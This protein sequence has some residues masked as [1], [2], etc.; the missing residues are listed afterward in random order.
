MGLFSGE[1]VGTYEIVSRIGQGGMG[2]VYRARDSKL[3]REV[4]LKVLPSS[5]A[6]DPHRRSMLLHE[7]Q[8]LASLNHPSI[9]S[10]YDLVEAEHTLALVLEL[11]EGPTLAD[12]IAQGPLPLD[13]A[14]G[15]ALRIVDALDVAH[16]KGIVHRDLKPA[17]I[18]VDAAG[19][20]KVLDFGIAK[21]LATDGPGDPA[22]SPTFTALANRSGVILGT[23]AYMSPE[24]A[25]GK[26]VDK[27]ADIWAFGCVLFEMLTGRQMFSGDDLTEIL[28]AVMTSEPDWQLLPANTP[29]GVREIL[30]RCVKRSTRERLRDIADARAD[31][32]PSN[33]AEVPAAQP[34]SRPRLGVVLFQR[35]TD[36]V[37]INGSPAISPDGKM[38]AFVAE[39]HGRRHVWVRLLAG[40]TPLKLTRADV[41]HEAPRWA[42]DS[43]S[44]I[45]Y[46]KGATAGD[47]GT[48]WEISALGGIPRPIASALG[49]GDISHDG[50]RIAVFQAVD[51]RVEL[52]LISR[53]GATVDHVRPLPPIVNCDCP[54]WSPDD[55]EIAFQAH[56]AAYF[57]QRLFIVPASGSSHRDIVRGAILRGMTWLADG[58]TIV[59][60]SAAGSTLPYPPIFGL[61][62]INRDGSDDR[63]VT[64]DDTS[65]VEPD[66]HHSG[67]LV[68]S[69]LRSRSDIWKFP[70]TGTPVENVGAAVRVTHQAGRVQTPSVSPDGSE[71]VYLSDS[72]GHATLWVTEVATGETRQVT[73]EQDSRNAVGVPVW[74]PKGDLI[75]FLMSREGQSRLWVVRPDGNGLRQ[76]ESGGFY[77]C[78]SGDGDWLYYSPPLERPSRIMKSPL[79]GGPAV[80]VRVDNAFSPAVARDGQT[81]YYAAMINPGVGYSD[82]EIRAA[83]PE[84]GPCRVLATVSGAQIPVSPTLLHMFLAPDGSSLALPLTNG[85]ST[86]LWLLPTN[87]G[88][89]RP[90][91]DFAGRSTMIARR[92]AWAPDGLSLYAAVEE[93]N[94]DVISLEGVFG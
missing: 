19:R 18:K 44:L 60:S 92:I 11:V 75:A 56:A 25:K 77:A 80:E 70:V 12:R 82:C 89:L 22:A 21:A 93:F 30:K 35:L 43:S 91:T 68:A 3:R 38:V 39:S 61:R 34:L 37:G 79:A 48:I 55:H 53:D 2:E 24:Q 28:V 88:S 78:W 58:R 52:S 42:P 66:L 74:S 49:G 27:R 90:V 63:Q 50:R 29:Q 71:V 20:V 41:D 14:L 45:Y 32:E 26:A 57:D 86:N 54:R 23:A 10:I 36:F 33:D 9:A 62:A 31:L 69:R 73:F 87:G 46:T 47:M 83:Q 15:I 85:T 7:A 72:G 16:E 40:G 59:Y 13:E 1:R 94:G 81:L 4:A 65:Y 84:D 76:L 5:L 51:G 6:D 8:I 64:F 67:R 17:N